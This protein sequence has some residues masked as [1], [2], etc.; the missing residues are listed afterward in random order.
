MMPSQGHA[1]AWSPGK[2]VLVVLRE[3]LPEEYLDEAL[4]FA[5]A[6]GA[7][8][9]DFFHEREGGGL[10]NLLDVANRGFYGAVVFPPLV[11]G[12]GSRLGGPHIY[13]ELFDS[14]R[15]LV[16][17]PR[18]SFP[19]ERIALAGGG[20]GLDDLA[21]ATGAEI[22]SLPK[23]LGEKDLLVVYRKRK[24]PHSVFSPDRAMVLAGTSRVSALV[25]P[26]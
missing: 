2:R 18:G 14:I 26:M 5:G 11:F 24:T 22:V 7:E 23:K 13:R 16:L 6:T 17:L 15:P 19:Y 1:F 8:D 4:Y 9:A 20:H 3:G 12:A 10:E 21:R 25:V